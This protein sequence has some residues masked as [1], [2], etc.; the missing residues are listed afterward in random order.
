M[1]VYRIL[2]FLLL[3]C[4]S[5]LAGREFIRF[6]TGNSDISY[7][8][9]NEIFQDSQGFVW[10]GTFKGLNRYDGTRFR[11]WYREDLGLASDF[12][13]QIA[14]DRDGNLWIGT[15]AGVTCYLRDE[16]RFEPLKL[17]ADNIHFLR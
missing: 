10:I 6:H 11:V 17:L 16:D 12:I 7:D 3:L 8:G 1:K 14:E 9:I 2:V 5:S 4:P 13:H 15:D